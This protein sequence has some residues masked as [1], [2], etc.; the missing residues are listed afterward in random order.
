MP[1][2]RLK[3]KEQAERAFVRDKRK[4]GWSEYKINDGLNLIRQQNRVAEDAFR[5]RVDAYKSTLSEAGTVAS[6]VDRVGAAT[7]GLAEAGSFGGLSNVVG[8]KG[9]AAMTAA[10]ETYPGWYGAGE[11]GAYM[12]PGS[13]AKTAAVGGGKLLARGAGAL[14]GR[15]AKKGIPGRLTDATARAYAGG[16][17]GSAA[18]FGGESLVDLAFNNPGNIDSWDNAVRNAIDETTEMAGSGFMIGLSAGSG[19]LA[20]SL[21]RAP[22]KPKMQ[23][24]RRIKRHMPEFKVSPDMLRDGTSIQQ[25]VRNLSHMPFFK[26]FMRQYINDGFIKPMNE[27]V[28]RIVKKSSGR[29]LANQ[30][31]QRAADVVRQTVGSGPARPGS[32]ARARQQKLKTAFAEEGQLPIARET[33]RWMENFHV[34]RNAERKTSR[35]KETENKELK[36]AMDALDDWFWHMRRKGSTFGPGEGPMGGKAPSGTNVLGRTP[37]YKTDP[38]TGKRIEIGEPDIN[39]QEIADV[40]DSLADLTRVNKIFSSNKLTDM[41]L[42]GWDLRQAQR[43]QA[44]LSHMLRETSRRNG[45]GM[46]DE[47]FNTSKVIQRELK[48]LEPLV[49]GIDEDEFKVLD[50]VFTAPNAVKRWDVFMKHKTAEEIQAIRGWYVKRFLERNVPRGADDLLVSK[51]KAKAA[52]SEPTSM[53]RRPLFDKIMGDSGQVRRELEDLAELTALGQ[54][55][56]LSFE[57]SATAGRAAEFIIYGEALD[58]AINAHQATGMQAVM[59]KLGAVG[60]YVLLKSTVTDGRAAKALNDLATG[61]AAPVPGRIGGLAAEQGGGGNMLQSGMQIG[62]TGMQD[63]LGLLQLMGK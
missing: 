14:T 5:E 53:F 26:G 18:I 3:K 11:F 35:F 41:Q 1:P 13:A 51:T 60:A 59:K 55:G 62:M 56:M 36:G 49:K 33:Y 34:W 2:S 16:V 31:P 24:I 25:L 17:G 45:M 58:M 61:K 44:T 12:S 9:R 4:Q 39:M 7:V 29:T 21:R 50:K 19:I 46:V 30:T 28:N 42:S 32:V 37:R 20:S 40:W 8:E 47:A 38:R 6:G 15:L 52:T 27:A 23:L 10:Q 54:K 48:Y 43:L 57:G 63:T 22:D